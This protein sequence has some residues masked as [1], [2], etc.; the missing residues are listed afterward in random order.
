MNHVTC[1]IYKRLSNKSKIMIM[2]SKKLMLI[3]LLLVFFPLASNAST[4]P[5]DVD[6][7]N[8]Q[9]IHDVAL[10]IDY[11]LSGE[12][13]GIVLENADVTGDGT[14]SINDVTA[15]I[16]DLLSGGQSSEPKTETFTVNGVSFTMVTVEGG[17]FMMGATAE[18]GTTDPKE[19]EY[20]V[21]QVTLSTY[22]IGQ[23]E[24]TQELWEAVMAPINQGDPRYDQYIH[25]SHFSAKNGYA[26]NPQRP[27]EGL[28][29]SLI[30]E[31]I[32]ELNRLTGREFFAPSEAQWEFAARGG[33]LSKG[34]KY[35]GSDNYDEV[36]W[37]VFNAYTVGADSPDYGTHT[38]GTKAPNELG[39]YDMSGNV[40]EFCLDG[41][42][43]YTSE[44]VTDPCNAYSTP[45]MGRGGCWESNPNESRVSAR[46]LYPTQN[47]DE[48]GLRLALKPL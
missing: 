27:V 36:S 47:G 19:W 6:G 9:S 7:D 20:P 5:G 35:A 17:T 23:T 21:H 38:V 29:Y 2:K 34:Y 48:C 32:Y 18:Q 25:P 8:S 3:T 41:F 4:L 15:P 30:Y 40:M 1:N 28:R 16:D 42:A 39:L 24:V 14:V 22:C 44:P 12:A 45:Y 46:S 33:N 10:L 31:F 13:S 43:Y 37:H 11:L 26:D